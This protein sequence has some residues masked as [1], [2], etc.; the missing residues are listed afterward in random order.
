MKCNHI[1]IVEL[2]G[3]FAAIGYQTPFSRLLF[4]S[5]V[6]IS[7]EADSC[8]HAQRRVYHHNGTTVR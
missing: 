3:V 7:I 6:A 2:G 4:K 5:F 1:V 8:G